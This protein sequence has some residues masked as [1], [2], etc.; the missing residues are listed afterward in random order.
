MEHLKVK[1]NILVVGATGVGKGSIIV[2]LF[3]NGK[4]FVE[5][6]TDLKPQTQNIE[7]FN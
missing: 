5:I 3:K 1:I 7:K 4:D 6:S 2:A